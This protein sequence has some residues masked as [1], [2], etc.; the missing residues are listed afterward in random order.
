M[1][2]GSVVLAIMWSAP[3]ALVSAELSTAFPSNGGYITWVVEGLGP[4]LGFINAANG[5]AAAVTNLP[6]YP[7]LFVSTLQVR[8]HIIVL[9]VQSCLYAT[10]ALSRLCDESI[11]CHRHFESLLPIAATRS[12]H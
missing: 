6:L 8:F 5:L 7:V 2:V 10:Q 12:Q 3:Q 9:S 11:I 4:V 1:L